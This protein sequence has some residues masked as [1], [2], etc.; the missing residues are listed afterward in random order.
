MRSMIFRAGLW[1][2]LLAAGPLLAQQPN[3]NA[4]F[5]LPSPAKTDVAQRDD[6]LIE[7]PQYVLS[8]NAQLRRPNWVSWPAL[9]RHWSRDR[10]TVRARSLAAPG[11]R[12]GDQPYLRS[13]RF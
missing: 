1:A 8:Y 5:G 6:Y 13:Q 2:I 4:R 9:R 7:R 3:P 12:S 11:V 10:R